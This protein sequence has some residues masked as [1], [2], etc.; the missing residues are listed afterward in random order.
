ML[1]QKKKRPE[2]AVITMDMRS[3]GIDF[4]AEQSDD[5]TLCYYVRGSK[6]VKNPDGTFNMLTSDNI[7]IPINEVDFH[8]AL[9][10]ALSSTGV[11]SDTGVS[12]LVKKHIR[13]K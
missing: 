1:K 8:T 2:N 6:Y 13:A 7:D 5:E 12:V 10:A 9:Q 11:S 3:D 4:F